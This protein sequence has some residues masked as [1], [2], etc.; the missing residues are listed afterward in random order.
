MKD[1]IRGRRGLWEGGHLTDQV[2]RGATPNFKGASK[3]DV[4]SQSPDLAKLN[5]K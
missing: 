1:G 2:W 5:L 3:H 4:L